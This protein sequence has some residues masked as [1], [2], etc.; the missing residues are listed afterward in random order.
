MDKS[1]WA[2]LAVGLAVILFLAGGFAL[3]IAKSCSTEAAPAGERLTCEE[4]TR[5]VDGRSC[6]FLWCRDGDRRRGGLTL[7]GCEE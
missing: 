5:E 6:R 3:G 4:F 1:E 2:W 7:L